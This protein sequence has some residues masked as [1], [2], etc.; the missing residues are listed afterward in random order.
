MST[1]ASTSDSASTAAYGWRRTARPEPRRRR[2]LVRA[3]LAGGLVLGVGSAATLAA[4]T[5]TEWVYGDGSADGG[6]SGVAASVFEVEQNV[7][8]GVGG[9]ANFVN[10]ETQPV[11]GGL[12]FSPLK[13]RALSPSDLV[14]A[15]MQLRTAVGSAAANV[16]VAPALLQAGDP[17]FFGALRYSVRSGVPQ[18]ACG[19]AAFAPATALGTELVT[20]A[21]LSTG[22][23]AGALQLGAATATTAGAPVDLCFAIT[24]PGGSPD[25]LQGLGATPVWSFTSQS[26]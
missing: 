26:R 9:V 15:P 22:S 16:T 18:G 12:V 13:A 3:L 19:D 5:D 20:S 4:W 11:A 23:T 7:W 14:Y 21:P 6:V 25:S 24:L 2:G 1:D 8:D 10:R 17:T